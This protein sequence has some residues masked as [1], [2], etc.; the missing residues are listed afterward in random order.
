MFKSTDGGGN[1]SAFN[2]GLTHTYVRSLAIDPVA[3]TTLYAGTWGGGVFAIQMI[4]APANVTISG[5]AT[6]MPYSTHAFTASVEPI[7]TT[8]PITY[9]WEAAGQS[10][11]TTTADL[12][13]TVTFNWSASGE[14]VITV[15]AA[16]AAGMV[17]DT[18]IISINHVPPSEVVISGPTT[19]IINTAYAFKATVGPGTA[20]TPI[21]YT[22]SPVPNNGQGTAVVSFTWVISGDKTITVT[23]ENTSGTARYA[24]SDT[25]VIT[26]G[27]PYR[28]YLPL[29][30]RQ[31]T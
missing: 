23:A 10:P 14:Q 15:T 20:T 3:P 26:I 9:V 21:T 24:V 29:V 1:W 6:G 5:P 11:M 16:N 2:T 30:L 31:S 17:S 22:W 19:G 25:H 27:E 28:I 12:T 8:T 13:S 18:H 7:T 4:T